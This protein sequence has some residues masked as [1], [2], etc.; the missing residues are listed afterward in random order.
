V[1]GHFHQRCRQRLPRTVEP[2][3]SHGGQS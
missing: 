2:W 3:R 1:F